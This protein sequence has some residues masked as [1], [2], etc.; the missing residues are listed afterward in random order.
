MSMLKEFL[1]NNS[2][3]RHMVIAALI[4]G[5]GSLAASLIDLFWV[6]GDMSISL[7]WHHYIVMVGLIVSNL[8]C[9]AGFIWLTKG[10]FTYL[11]RHSNKQL[12]AKL[13]R[14]RV[15]SHDL[16]IKELEARINL[17]EKQQVEKL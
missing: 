12:K 5:F 3:F 14:K 11:T 4:F 13:T 8:L 7:H 15:K 10:V 2:A 6:I 9:L 17:L 1:K 16:H